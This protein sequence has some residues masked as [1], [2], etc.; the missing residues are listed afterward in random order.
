[1]KAGGC[2]CHSCAS[3]AIHVRRGIDLSTLS[4][5]HPGNL[6]DVV[7]RL[8][9]VAFDTVCRDVVEQ[10]RAVLTGGTLANQI[11]LFAQQLLQGYGVASDDSVDR[12]FE[13]RY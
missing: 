10:S 11:G 9:P 13:F 12:R 7:R 4:Q 3:A 6:Y 8:L 1:M 2:E 5:Q